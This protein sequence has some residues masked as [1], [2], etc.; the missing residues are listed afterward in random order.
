[1][2]AKLTN[3]IV[4]TIAED[5]PLIYI[6]EEAINLKRDNDKLK[7]EIERLNDII[8][9]K[10]EGIKALTEDLCDTTLE[11]KKRKKANR[12]LQRIAN[13]NEIKNFVLKNIIKE[14]LDKLTIKQLRFMNETDY[15]LDDND[16]D[17]IMKIL[18]KGE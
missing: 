14:A 18:D 2:E 8:K 6:S 12:K 11:L 10:D 7:Q 4:S 3:D 1:V 16:L 15:V 5:K 17:E 13:K 9:T